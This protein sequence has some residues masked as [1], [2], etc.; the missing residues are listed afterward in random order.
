VLPGPPIDRDEKKQ[1]TIDMEETD[2]FSVIDEKDSHSLSRSS[3]EDKSYRFGSIYS[4][5]LNSN[6]A[7]SIKGLPDLK[8]N[9]SFADKADK[10]RKKY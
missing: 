8:K 4:K 3:S 10:A 1:P 2:D 9:P 7:K 5:V 6:I